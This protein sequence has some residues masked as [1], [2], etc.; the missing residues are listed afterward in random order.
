MFRVKL[1][2]LCAQ[3]AHRLE[4]CRF[5]VLVANFCILA[6][7][8]IEWL[9]FYLRKYYFKWSNPLWRV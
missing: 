5:L 4:R 6:Y 8:L 7:T 1:Q 2:T 9:L 3:W